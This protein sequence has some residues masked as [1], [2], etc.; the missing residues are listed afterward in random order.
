MPLGASRH[1]LLP[2]C[3]V[4]LAARNRS[5]ATA[6]GPRRC[7]VTLTLGSPAASGWALLLP[8]LIWLPVSKT[9]R[10]CLIALLLSSA[11]DTTAGSGSS[12]ARLSPQ[13]ARGTD[14]RAEMACYTTIQERVKVRVSANTCSSGSANVGSTVGARTQYTIQSVL[15]QRGSPVDKAWE[16]I[17]FRGRL[18]FGAPMP[19]R[20]LVVRQAPHVCH[21]TTRVTAVF[22]GEE[23]Q[24]RRVRQMSI[25]DGR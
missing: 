6:P 15:W 7:R 19:L 13:A 5:T 2:K 8:R 1:R 21:L 9:G 20:P 10:Q 12:N 17:S 4:I 3:P 24:R 16:C 14:A 25:S 18:D 23:E 11:V 22:L